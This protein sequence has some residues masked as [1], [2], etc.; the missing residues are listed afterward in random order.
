M[1][2]YMCNTVDLQILGYICDTQGRWGEPD[3][4]SVFT[5][6][7]VALSEPRL[8]QRTLASGLYVDTPNRPLRTSAYKGRLIQNGVASRPADC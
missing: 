1:R 5:L 8:R 4:V 7:N 2:M 3:R 6:V